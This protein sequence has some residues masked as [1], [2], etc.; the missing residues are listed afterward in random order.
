MIIDDEVPE[1]RDATIYALDLGSLVAGAKYRG[2]FEKRLKAVL[3]QL[4]MNTTPFYSSTK[5]TPSS[6]PARRPAG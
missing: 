6:A 5:F 3:A 2:D 4:R 1:L